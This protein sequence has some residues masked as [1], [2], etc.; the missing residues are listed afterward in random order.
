[1]GSLPWER[2]VFAV[3]TVGDDLMTES[4]LVKI[5]PEPVHRG[6][7]LLSPPA[8]PPPLSPVLVPGA[9]VTS[10]HKLN[11]FRN[12]IVSQSKTS[13]SGMRSRR[14]QGRAPPATSAPPARLL[15]SLCSWPASAGCGLPGLGAHRS[16]LCLCGHVCNLTCHP[17]PCVC[18]LS[19]PLLGHL[20]GI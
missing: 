17:L 19:L 5:F 3:R 20:G 18:P 10:D 14:P 8:C 2:R 16:S 13:I 9:G 1:M 11:G 7:P 4:G 15:G 6:Q 12:L